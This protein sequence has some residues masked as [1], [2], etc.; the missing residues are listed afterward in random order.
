MDRYNQSSLACAIHALIDFDAFTYIYMAI[1][2]I[3]FWTQPFWHA[4]IYTIIA[5]VLI[6]YANSCARY[7]SKL[8]MALVGYIYV[9]LI[10]IAAY[11]VSKVVVCAVNNLSGK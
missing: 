10:V 3:V 2:F 11:A 7:V 5:I 9:S 8:A 4:V 6:A 1:I